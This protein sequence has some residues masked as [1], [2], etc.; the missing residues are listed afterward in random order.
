MEGGH[1]RTAAIQAVFC[2]AIDAEEGITAG[3]ILLTVDL[4]IEVGIKPACEANVTDNNIIGPGVA[5]AE[6]VLESGFFRKPC[7]VGL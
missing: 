2:S 7:Q 4:F 6:G 1:R 5:V 3:P